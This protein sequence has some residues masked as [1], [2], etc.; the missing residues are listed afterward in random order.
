MTPGTFPANYAEASVEL[1]PVDGCNAL[2]FEPTIEARPT[3]N[4]ADAPSG[5]EFNLH[6]PQNEDPEGV[7]TPELKEAVVKLPKG[8]SLNPPRAKAC[9]VLHEAQIGL[10]AEEAAALP[11]CLQARHRR[12]Q[13]AAAARTARRASLYLATP[14]QNPSGSLLAGYIVLE[15][16]GHQD[17]AR[18]AASKPTRRPARSPPAS[19]KTPSCPSKN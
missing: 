2:S 13:D 17:Q 6:V 16:A 8:L 14:H 1:P 12:S 11:R 5:L 7:A 19:P 15:G 18:R 10:H 4:L 3:T 9:R